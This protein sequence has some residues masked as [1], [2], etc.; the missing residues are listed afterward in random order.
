MNIFISWSGDLSH[1]V[2]LVLK[3]W[4]PQVI[5][6]LNIFVSSEDIKKGGRWSLS[7]SEELKRTQFGIICV[8][9]E[10]INSPWINF[11][12]GAISNTLGENVCPLLIDIKQK[13]LYG[14][15]A[16]FQASTFDKNEFTILLRSINQC[17][18]ELQLK[19]EQLN[20]CFDMWWD[21]F[22]PVLKKAVTQ[23]QNN[24][25][26]DRKTEDLI[27]EILYN[28]R[29]IIQEQKTQRTPSPKWHKNPY[30]QPP[31]GK[32]LFQP[33]SRYILEQDKRYI[34]KEDGGIERLPWPN[35]MESTHDDLANPVF[36]LGRE[37]ITLTKINYNANNFWMLKTTDEG[38]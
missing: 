6:S 38:E 34:L 35:E 7:I 26:P 33:N 10:N 19:E 1:K 22:E 8:T 12:A 13:D 15:L 16:Q 30:T 11:E 23:K 20:R 28:T 25:I 21:K 31:P 17:N 9:S 32:Y 27:E 5:Q 37:L 24:K 4:L 3:E 18:K 14:P 29:S 36:C 2:A